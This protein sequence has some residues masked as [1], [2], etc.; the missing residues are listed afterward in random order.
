MRVFTEVFIHV[1]QVDAS[2]GCKLSQQFAGKK[3]GTISKIT[4]N[5]ARFNIGRC[6]KSLK[7]ET[8]LKHLFAAVKPGFFNLN[9][10]VLIIGFEPHQFYPGTAECRSDAGGDRKC[11]VGYDM[12]ILCVEPVAGLSVTAFPG[13]HR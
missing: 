12:A 13:A 7:S 8:L 1:K 11:I 10:M 2:I 4:G 5:L 9:P 6:K 3:A